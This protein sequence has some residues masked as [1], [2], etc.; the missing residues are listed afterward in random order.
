MACLPDRGASGRD[1]A[2]PWCHPA[3]RPRTAPRGAARP[4]EGPRPRP[5]GTCGMLLERLHDKVASGELRP[6]PLQRAAAER[7]DRLAR[8]LEAYHPAP[9][10]PANGGGFLARLGLA[11]E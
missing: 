1:D 5:R 7:L 11:R 10:K 4:L 8:E 9:S 6:D 3:A 2:T